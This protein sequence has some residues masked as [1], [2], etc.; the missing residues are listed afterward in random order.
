MNETILI[1]ILFVPASIV[2]FGKSVVPSELKFQEYS[3]FVI[4]N[5]PLTFNEPVIC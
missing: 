1:S 4:A 5:S 3:L 2:V